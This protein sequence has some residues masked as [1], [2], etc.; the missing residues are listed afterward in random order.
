MPTWTK[1]PYLLKHEPAR[2]LGAEPVFSIL[3]RNGEPLESGQPA[4]LLAA[5]V[6][7]GG[8]PMAVGDLLAAIGTDAGKQAV[9]QAQFRINKVL[10]F[11]VVITPNKSRGV[12]E[13]ASTWQGWTLA[14]SE[15]AVITPLPQPPTAE[16]NE[17]AAEIARKTYFAYRNEATSVVQSRRVA[18]ELGERYGCPPLAVGGVLLPITALWT[19]TEGVLSPDEL[20]GTL[21]KGD[22]TPMSKS[23][24]L[25]A[26]EYHEAREFMGLECRKG[27]IKRENLAYRMTSIDIGQ[28]IPRI[29]GAF[30]W[31]YD[32]LLTQYAMEWELRW[33]LV[34]G[35]AESLDSVAN[36]G[37]LPLRESVERGRNPTIDGSGRCASI[38]VSTLFVYKGAD[39]ILY[40]ILRRR[41]HLVMVAPGLHHVVPGGMFEAWNTN[42]PWS[43]VTNI[44]TELLEEVYKRPELMGTGENRSRHHIAGIEPIPLVR[45]L[46]REGRAEL[47]V[48]GLTCNLLNLKPEICTVL[49]VPDSSLAEEGP[50]MQLNWEFTDEGPASRFAIPWSELPHVAD[51][52]VKQG[53]FAVSG[54]ACL[55]L[56]R[57]WLKKQHGI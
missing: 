53:Q 18:E 40:S 6:Q 45:R 11:K 16:G 47:S 35:T 8:Q 39:E 10:E 34:G 4:H 17:R 37:S 7:A 5:L 2:S 43:V 30:G 1:G 42:E 48:T 52:L 29:N 57:R 3:Y 15:K 50:E 49:Y 22:P 55:E 9:R 14:A 26:S 12:R 23:A 32:N 33:A 31:Y 56:G 25:T 46:L 13:L 24:T 21:D 20:L 27:P 19:N 44:W 38:T 36:C 28:G 51:R 54:A 41:S